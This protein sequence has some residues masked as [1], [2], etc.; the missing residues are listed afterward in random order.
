MRNLAAVLREFEAV[1]DDVE[2]T[3]RYVLGEQML[4]NFEAKILPIDLREENITVTNARNKFSMF[5]DYEKQYQSVGANDLFVAS[6]LY[7]QPIFFRWKSSRF[8]RTAGS[9]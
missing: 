7:N 2:F 6:K 3:P 5:L 1:P 9:L 8:P 4:P